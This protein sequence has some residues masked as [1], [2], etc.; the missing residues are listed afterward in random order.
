MIMSK[1]AHYIET[2]KEI[3][4]VSELLREAIRLYMDER[5]WLRQE[6]R[7]RARF[8]QAG[9]GSHKYQKGEGK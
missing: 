1:S 5:A 8:R 2:Q 6:R 4:P 3:V 7:E 9:Q